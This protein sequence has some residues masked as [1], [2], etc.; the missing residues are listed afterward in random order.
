[1]AA[2]RVW[3]QQRTRGVPMRPIR[4]KQSTMRV[5]SCTSIRAKG[6]QADEVIR[7]WV[8]IAIWHCTYKITLV[9]QCPNGGHLVRM[10]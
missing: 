3:Q 4:I 5:D 8:G 1:M 10:M 2:A 9:F 6:L 7:L